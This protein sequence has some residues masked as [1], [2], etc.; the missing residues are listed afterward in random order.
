MANSA[1]V[2][3]MLRLAEREIIEEFD[4]VASQ[5]SVDVV[6]LALAMGKDV[7]VSSSSYGAG[8]PVNVPVIVL[9]VLVHAALIFVLVH[10]RQHVLRHKEER[11]SVVN[12][13]TP[14]PPP[15]EKAPPPP[16]SK[17]E[18]VAPTPVVNVPVAPPPIATTPVAVPVTPRS[19]VEASPISAPPVAAAAPSIVQGGDLSA[20]MVA[21]SP[22][23]YPIESRRKR[24]QGTVVLNLTL[25]LDGGVDNIAVSRSSGFSRLDHAALDA[26]RK[27]RWRPVIRNGQ[28][29]RV[30]GVVEIPFVIQ[31]K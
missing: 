25:G 22:P 10:A 8:R 27:W 28:P 1:G 2:N 15:A 5:R 20:Q 11:L 26:V 30:S 23:R 17:P 4:A 18:I 7:P 31:E 13:L 9:I 21:G 6:P 3:G 19:N 29:V 14:P 12:L 24:E 16:P